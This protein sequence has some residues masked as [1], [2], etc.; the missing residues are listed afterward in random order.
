MR[1]HWYVAAWSDEVARNL[2][3]RWILEA[4]TED[5]DAL[6]AIEI[7]HDR[8]RSIDFHEMGVSSDRAGLQMRRI[9]E[10]QAD[11]EAARGRAR[12]E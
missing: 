7:V 6:E 12:I 2:M 8:D 3:K 10:K 11:A 1:D 4:F 5:K 9:I